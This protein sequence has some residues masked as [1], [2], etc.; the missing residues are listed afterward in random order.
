MPSSIMKC[1]RRRKH[2]NSCVYVSGHKL[3]KHERERERKQERVREQAKEIID[4]SIRWV[5]KVR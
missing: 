5:K 2:S 1:D 4:Q 3:R